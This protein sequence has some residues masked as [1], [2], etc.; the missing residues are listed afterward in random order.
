MYSD[1]RQHPRGHGLLS[2]RAELQLLSPAVASWNLLSATLRQH[3][4]T[5]PGVCCGRWPKPHAVLHTAD[6]CGLNSCTQM[7]TE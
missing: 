5:K 2:G 7:Q 1:H 4:E 3:M 6:I